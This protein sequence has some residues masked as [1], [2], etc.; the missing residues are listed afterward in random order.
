MIESKA[1]CSTEE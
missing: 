1:T